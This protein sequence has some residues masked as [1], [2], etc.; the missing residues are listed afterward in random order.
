MDAVIIVHI[1]GIITPNIFKI[2]KICEKF[3]VPLI[4]YAAQ[5][6]GSSYKNIFAGNF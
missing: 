6:H 1:G 5:D 4:E 2:K 3:K